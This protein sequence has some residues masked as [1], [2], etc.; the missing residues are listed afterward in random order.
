MQVGAATLALIALAGAAAQGCL[1][2]E[3]PT[4]AVSNT[5]RCSTEPLGSV[6]VFE[7]AP[8]DAGSW[9]FEATLTAVIPPADSGLTDLVLEDSDGARREFAFASPAGLPPLQEGSSYVFRFDYVGGEPDAA[10][11]VIRD[12]EG[13]LFAAATDQRP[14][15]AVLRDGLDGF[16]LSLLSPECDSRTERPCYEAVRNVGFAVEHGGARLVLFQGESTV[17]GRYRIE[18]LIA[19]EITYSPNCADA[20][21]PGISYVITRLP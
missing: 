2:R 14:G 17:L 19:Q 3:S 9:T 13:L 10:A 16:T 11:L 5:D 8:L 4:T 18:C 6:T 7:R 12:Q 15:A 20:G 1:P 21:L